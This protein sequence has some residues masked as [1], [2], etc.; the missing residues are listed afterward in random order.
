[1]RVVFFLLSLRVRTKHKKTKLVGLHASTTAYSSSVM[2]EQAR[3]DTLVTL[4]TFVSTR[5]T[6]RTCRV[7]TWR[8]KWNLGYSGLHKTWSDVC[9]HRGGCI[10]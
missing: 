8:A 5:S 7:E 10:L 1:M 2:L 4:D 3:L 6:R 9:K